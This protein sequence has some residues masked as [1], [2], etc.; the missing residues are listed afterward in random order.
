[1]KQKHSDKMALDYLTHFQRL[2]PH[3]QFL[4]VHDAEI[5]YPRIMETG[6]KEY[7]FTGDSS[8]FAIPA[9]FQAAANTPV[10]NFPQSSFNA[11]PVT[12]D[13]LMTIYRGTINNITYDFQQSL[14]TSATSSTTRVR[15]RFTAAS[16][17]VL[18]AWGGHIAS[19]LDWGFIG[20]TPRSAGGISGSPYHMR[21]IKIVNR[22][23]NDTISLGNTDRSL[24][25]AAVIAPPDCPTVRIRYDEG[26]IEGT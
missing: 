26:L 7:L 21:S 6:S 15:I 14:T 19:R 23:T 25:A 12:P 2:L 9:P 17:S 11:L 22:N 3:G 4:P 18:F 1:M 24:S 8:T 16:D 20:T 10:A 13:R 5:I